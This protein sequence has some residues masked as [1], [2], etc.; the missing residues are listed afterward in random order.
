MFQAY[1]LCLEKVV[2]V[3]F[4]KCIFISDYGEDHGASYKK[5]W[6]CLMKILEKPYKHQGH[7]QMI[8]LCEVSE[9]H[10]ACN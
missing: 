10:V 8:L 5:Q 6:V 4:K 7:Y 9:L 1:K 2:Y 3:Y